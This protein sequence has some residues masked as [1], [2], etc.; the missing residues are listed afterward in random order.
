MDFTVNNY[1]ALVLK[2]NEWKETK[3]K[4]V[5]N[6]FV[7]HIQISMR[8]PESESVS[9]GMHGDDSWEDSNPKNGVLNFFVTVKK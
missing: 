6:F 2:D 7:K 3:W 9:F 8:L 1:R 5:S 4:D